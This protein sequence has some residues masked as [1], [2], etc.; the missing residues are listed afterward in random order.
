MLNRPTTG[1]N[2]R[3]KNPVTFLISKPSCAPK[4][5]AANDLVGADVDLPR[6]DHPDAP[7]AATLFGESPSRIVVSAVDV[8]AVLG[9]ARAAGVPARALGTTQPALE[10]RLMIGGKGPWKVDLRAAKTARDA[11]LTPIVGD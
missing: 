10:L 5:R 11:C 9:A 6:V 7:I 8:E 2:R 1:C 4:R 3:C